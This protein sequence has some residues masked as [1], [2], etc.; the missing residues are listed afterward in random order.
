MHVVN[1][2]NS[3]TAYWPAAQEAHAAP[4]AEDLPAEQPLQFDDEVEPDAPDLPLGQRLQKLL[5]AVSLYLLAS[6]TVHCDSE[7]APAEAEYL[8][9]AHPVQPVAPAEE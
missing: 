2:P 9:A 4:E 5:S 3:F 8:P 7:D 1:D 6:H